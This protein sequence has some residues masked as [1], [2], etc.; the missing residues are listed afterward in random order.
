[1]VGPPSPCR[2]FVIMS[3]DLKTTAELD[4][5]TALERGEVITQMTLKQRIGVSVGLINA[6]LKRAV[7]KGYVKIRRAPYKRYAYYL[8]PQGF[9]EKSRLVAEYL[10]NSL[11]FLR[12]VRAQYSEIFTVESAKGHK[13]FILAGGGE[14]A[15][16]AIL[17]AIGKNLHLTIYDPVYE[18]T[19]LSGVGVVR[20]LGD[21]NAIII[22]TDSL[23]PQDCFERLLEI[24]PASKI[25]APAFLR[26]TP[27]RADLLHDSGQ[28]ERA[29]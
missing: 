8:T 6:L 10:E 29:A 26:I 13:R 24:C 11:D 27:D 22:I 4:F 23:N 19:Q 17:A 2:K 7:N 18:Q 28:V 3:K 1:M 14:L 12:Q 5:L 21:E 25:K 20:E 16:I 15:E 9:S